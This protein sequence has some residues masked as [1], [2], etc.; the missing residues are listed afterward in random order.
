VPKW[1]DGVS[2]YGM[3]TVTSITVAQGWITS[4][5]PNLDF[6]FLTVAPRSGKW[7]A[8]QNV[9]GGL[10]LG[11]N[12]GYDHSIYVIGYNNTDSEPLGCAAT[13]TE[14]EANQM[15]FYC[16]D[17]WDGTSGGPWILNFNP[18]TGSGIVFGDIGGYEQGGDYPY[19]S[20]SPYYTW[21]I[22]PLF[23]RAQLAS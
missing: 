16:N 2:P 18:V 6:A 11:V 22:M 1:H 17:Y 3:W 8:I 14:F 12:R 13:S 4:H 21:S 23:L 7:R 20:Y 15:Q 10:Q 19:L 5:D 9:T